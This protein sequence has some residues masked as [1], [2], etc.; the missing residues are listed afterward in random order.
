M[1]EKYYNDFDIRLQEYSNYSA[2]RIDA[3]EGQVVYSFNQL[4]YDFERIS[5]KLEILEQSYRKLTT[6]VRDIFN[7]N[8][9]EITE[10]E[11]ED[12]LGL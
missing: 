12:I 4:E 10:E 2:A 5:E 9:V 3:M 1:N 6:A 11:F 7:E 8:G